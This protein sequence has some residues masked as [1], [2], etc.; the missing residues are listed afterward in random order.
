MVP[1]ALAGLVLASAS[2]SARADR[3][4]LVPRRL[5]GGYALGYDGRRLGPLGEG[6]A[7]SGTGD[8]AFWFAEPRDMQLS[9]RAWAQWKTRLA[10]E[11]TRIEILYERHEWAQGRILGRNL[12]ELEVR[13]DLGARSSLELAVE[14]SPQIYRRHRLDEDA[15]PGEPRYRPQAFR[16]TE[17]ELEYLRQ[18]TG[19]LAAGL[20]VTHS[21]RDENSWFNE[22]DR[23]RSGAGLAVE[24]PIA[25]LI[26]LE[27]T[28][29]YRVS[30]Y[31]N[32]PNLG[33]DRA[34]Y[35]HLAELAL[36]ADLP[37]RGGPWRLAGKVRWKFRHYTTDDPE[38]ESRYRRGDRI[39]YW[40]VKL[41]HADAKVTPFVSAEISGRWV[42][43]P[44]DPGD[45]DDEDAGEVDHTLVR[46]GVE[47]TVELGN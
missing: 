35:E 15:A 11:R 30:R 4:D 23:W 31:R 25:G 8:P 43:A 40:T 28:Y 32:K 41:C 18:W 29:E 12:W 14:Y 22:R 46:L 34:Y 3:S 36:R 39:Y 21:Y 2:L 16:E 26:E 45:P 13:Q 9:I 27:P 6:D 1:L 38:D 42:D 24:F 37:L 7:E 33:T 10:G 20:F 44:A 5:G 19:D 47:W 17:F